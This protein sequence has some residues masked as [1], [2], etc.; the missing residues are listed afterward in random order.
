M[1]SFLRKTCI[2]TVTLLLPA[3]VLAE[4]TRLWRQ[5]TFD[6]LSKGTAKGIAIRSNGGLELAPAFKSLATTPSTYIWAIASD[7]AGNVY[8]AA[9]APARVYQVTANGAANAIFEPQELQVQALLVDKNGVIFAATNPDGKVYRIEHRAPGSAPR[10]DSK[11]AKGTATSSWSASVYFDP[12]TKY[13]WD[14]ALDNAGN[15]YVATG[16]QGEIFRVTPKGEHSV[17]FKSD[18]AHI[19]VLALDAQGNLI[20][21]SD[22]SG[23]VYRIS[24]GGEGFVLY[25]APKKEITALAIDKQG[26][27]YAAGVGEKHPNA[28]APSPTTPILM[29]A[30]GSAPN[31]GPQPQGVVGGQGPNVG[32]AN[33][34][35]VPG[36]PITGGS[37]IYRI[38]PDGS[39]ARLWTSRDDLVYAL[40]F[41]AKGQLI[42]GS[43]NQGHVLAITGEDQFTDLLHASASQVTAF[44]KAPAGGL[45]VSTSN[46]GKV[47]LLG[48]SPEAEGSYESDIFDAQVFSRWGRAEF[49]GSGDVDLLARSGNVD[50]PDRHWSPWTKV[51]LKKTA[52]I[53]VPS[54]RFVQ[55]KA[56]LHAGDPAP[57]LDSVGINY[58]P[59]NVA[60]DFD[61]IAIQP[62][63]HYQ[64]LPRQSG[65]DITLST[66][67][68]PPPPKFEAP[69]P[70]VH[71]PDSIGV[72]WSVHDDNDDQ[73]VY[74][75]YY[76]GDGEKRWLLLKDDLSDKFYS[77]DASLLPDG[78]YT[79]KVVA[80]DAPSHSPGEALTSERESARFEVDSTPPLIEGLT[81][82]LEGGKIH[83]AFRATDSFSPIKRAE[84]SIDA[85]DWQLIE[86][87]GQ[88]SDSKSESYDLKVPLVPVTAVAAGSS[89][90]VPEDEHVVVVRAYDRYDNMSAAKTVIRGK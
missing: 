14:L 60:P 59:K 15:L 84:C 24:P 1:Q 46:L 26:N 27:I 38:A 35:I 40:T 18:E 64:S 31:A 78:G 17:F 86:P 10:E 13:I 6:E 42:A 81:A 82:S 72:R 80:S 20:A 19:R 28:G 88:L 41:D 39:P 83:L 2:L 12:G 16:D 25:S 45:Y 23:L 67:N 90:A 63:V 71:D 54:A 66:S 85:G 8:A 51:D 49:R 7:S 73:M 50:N 87:V 22:G 61:D 21:G 53:S 57:D 32:M 62:G 55:W 77:F 5:S 89:V 65:P 76:R 29:P 37:E 75:V 52:E 48:A 58:L 69:P 43:G 9:G 11:A 47:F 68:G 36:G 4:G 30:P 44:A 33:R 74:A 3:L 79:I 34:F 56:V 70:S